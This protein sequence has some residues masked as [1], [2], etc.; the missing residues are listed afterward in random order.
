MSA[1]YGGNPVVHDLNFD[2][3]ARRG[4]R[5]ARPQRRRQ[6]DDAA[7]PGGRTPADL[8][9]R[10]HF[11]G[12]PPKAPL[13]KRARNG[14]VLR[15]RGALGVHGHDAARQPAGR[16]RRRRT[17]PLELFPELE[18]A[19][20]GRAAACSPA[21]S[22]RCSPSP[23]RSAASRACCWPTSSRSA[24]PRWSSIGS[25]M[26]FA[27]PPTSGTAVIMVEQHAHKALTYTDHAIVIRRGRVSLDLT[28]EQARARIGDVE[29]AYLTS[30]GGDIAKGDAELAA[31]QNSRP[32]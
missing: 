25:C 8:R 1:G 10:S 32:S 2:V 15:H 14:H 3:H 9:A 31:E 13:Y 28:G 11:A 22:S 29:Q 16:R 4:R 17:R 27:V 23:G 6:D 19:H 12:V 7:R 26:R 21:A 18:Q 24:S 5:P 30:A 20:D